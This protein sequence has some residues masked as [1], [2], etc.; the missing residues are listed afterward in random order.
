MKL[1]I[2]R[3]KNSE[4]RLCV[5]FSFVARIVRTDGTTGGR[6]RHPA[7]RANSSVETK[8]DAI[9]IFSGALLVSFPNL[10]SADFF[11]FLI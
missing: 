2:L 8:T 5:S 10:L 6:R 3:K 11:C 7:T 4:P 9:A 1:L